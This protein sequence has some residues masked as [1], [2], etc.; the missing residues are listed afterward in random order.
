MDELEIA[1]RSVVV[2]LFIVIGIRV[3]GTKKHQEAIREFG[4]SKIHRTSF[5]L[6][7]LSGERN[8]FSPA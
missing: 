3:F 5:D 2:Y 4:I 7:W 8:K 1:F 6:S